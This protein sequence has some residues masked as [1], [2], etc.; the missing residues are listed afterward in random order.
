MEDNKKCTTIWLRPSVICRMDAWMEEANCRSRSEFIEKAVCF[1]MGYWRWG[2]SSSL[3]G[4][5]GLPA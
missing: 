2:C 4:V 3:T 5:W 1:Y